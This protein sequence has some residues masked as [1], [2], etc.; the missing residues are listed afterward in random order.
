M[1]RVKA[2]ATAA[3]IMRPAVSPRV[4]GHMADL[5]RMSTPLL[6]RLS[7]IAPYFRTAR[8][9]FVAAFVA[10]VVA[11]ATEPLVPELLKRLLDDR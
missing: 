7:R 11:A 8:A 5:R 3:A 1:L 10:A 4:G 2:F 6:Q 9:G